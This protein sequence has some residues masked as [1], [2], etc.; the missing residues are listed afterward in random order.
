MCDIKGHS[1]KYGTHPVSAGACDQNGF[2]GQPLRDHVEYGRT[3]KRGIDPS[4]QSGIDTKPWQTPRLKPDGQPFKPSA[5]VKDVPVGAMLTWTE[6]RD[7]RSLSGIA[8]GER[9]AVTRT[10][11]VW[12]GHRKPG[13]VWVAPSD[14]GSAVAVE[15]KTLEAYRGF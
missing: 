6:Y 14:G 13:V 2:F 9:E 15:A 11:Q 12:S 4:I 7:V 10:G 5:A 8:T 3:A 1:L